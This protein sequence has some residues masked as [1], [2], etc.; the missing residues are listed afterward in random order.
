M[1][2]LLRDR[3]ISMILGL[4]GFTLFAVFVEQGVHSRFAGTRTPDDA[5]RFWERH[6]ERNGE[7]P[8][9]RIRLAI[10]YQEAKRFDDAQ[11]EYEAA[12]ALDSDADAAANGRY[13]ILVWKGEQDA[14]LRGLVEYTRSHSDCAVCWQ[15]LASEYLRLGQ[16]DEAEAA[17]EGLLASRLTEASG[18]YSVNDWHYEALVTAGRVS[19]ARGNFERATDFFYD[20]IHREPD[21]PRGYL[22]QA[23]SLL[24]EGKFESALSVLNEGV[25]RLGEQNAATRQEFERLQKRVLRRR[26]GR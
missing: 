7:Y 4:L 15:N 18:M 21:N 11:A 9:A 13:S 17:V 20:A 8:A 6:V 14:A 1:A 26:S 23:K 25:G 3:Q 2:W 19:A 22:L 5:V 16:L 12:L 24:A 10:A